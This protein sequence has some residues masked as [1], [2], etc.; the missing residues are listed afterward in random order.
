MYF[1]SQAKLISFSPQ[2]NLR[3]RCYHSYFINEETEAQRG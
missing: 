1:R 2:N 3:G